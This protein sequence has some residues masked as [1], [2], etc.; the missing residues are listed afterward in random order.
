MGDPL[1]WPRPTEE[2][3]R[4]DARKRP[5]DRRI[6]DKKEESPKPNPTEL[7]SKSR[8]SVQSILPNALEWDEGEDKF[9]SWNGKKT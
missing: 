3:I 6:S 9:T 8:L 4:N 5:P 2:P 1:D 7:K